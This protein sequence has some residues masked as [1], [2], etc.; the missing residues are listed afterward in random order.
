M[1]SRIYIGKLPDSVTDANRPMG[2]IRVYP[3]KGT[4]C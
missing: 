4:Q 3:L 1:P 2:S